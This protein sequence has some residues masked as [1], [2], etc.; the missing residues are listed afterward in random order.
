M[1]GLHLSPLSTESGITAEAVTKII[2]PLVAAGKLRHTPGDLLLTLESVE[3]A[4][5]LMMGSFDR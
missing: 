3:S 1:R 4:Q 5:R 2:S